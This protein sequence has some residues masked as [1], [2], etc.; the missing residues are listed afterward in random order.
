MG[1]VV[2]V[3]L[4]CIA[5]LVVVVVELVLVLELEVDSVV[6]QVLELGRGGNVVRVLGLG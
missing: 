3:G 6:A 2:G 1:L 5:G 4:G